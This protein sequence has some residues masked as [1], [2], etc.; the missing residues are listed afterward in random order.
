MA[1]YS[2]RMLLIATVLV[3]SRLGAGSYAAAAESQSS[4]VLA[5]SE[6][7]ELASTARSTSLL[8]QPPVGDHPKA[9]SACQALQT[10]DENFDA[11]GVWK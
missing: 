3:S 2:V 10:V 9:Q 7:A 4:F 11:D 1:S 8:C 5:I 6:G